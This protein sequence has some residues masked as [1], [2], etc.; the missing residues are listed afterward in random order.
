MIKQISNFLSTEELKL[1]QEYW[2]IKENFLNKCLQCPGSKSIYADILSET[3]L[4]IKTPIIEN[5]I[6]HKN[7]GKS[8]AD[9]KDKFNQE[10]EADHKDT[11]ELGGEP[12]PTEEEQR[13][14]KK[15]QTR[16]VEDPNNPGEKKKQIWIPGRGKGWIDADKL[17]GKNEATAN[18]MKAADGEGG[19]KMIIYPQGAEGNPF[20]G[21]MAGHGGNWHSIET[22]NLFDSDHPEYGGL[23]GEDFIAHH[24][25][26]KL[27]DHEGMKGNVPFEVNASEHGFGMS[28]HPAVNRRKPK[29]D[30]WFG[31]QA[32]AR[33]AY[34]SEGKEFKGA[35]DWLQRVGKNIKPGLG[36][37]AEASREVRHDYTYKKKFKPDKQGRASAMSEAF[38][39]M[40]HKLKPKKIRRLHERQ[41]KRD[42]ASA[43]AKLREHTR[44]QDEELDKY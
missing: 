23:S 30:G 7:L 6:A 35:L 10:N 26:N 12:T 18:N 38:R 19:G 15:G 33:A 21:A 3:L 4:K 5:A 17:D 16:M 22:D 39:Y 25:G 24:L 8:A 28:E 36:R 43:V 37:L 1:A 27:K 20:A 42:K 2:L 9:N 29:K 40:P 14:G 31:E 34:T 11:A 41:D 13:D 44:K 32:Q